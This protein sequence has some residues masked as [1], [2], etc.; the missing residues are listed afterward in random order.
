MNK[1]RLALP[2]VLALLLVEQQ[3]CPQLRLL[4]SPQPTRLNIMLAVAKR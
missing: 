2:G 4:L 1:M 3:R